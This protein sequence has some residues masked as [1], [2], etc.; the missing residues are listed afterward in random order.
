MLTWGEAVEVHA[1]RE[2]GWSIAAIARHLDRDPKTIRAYVN[3]EREPGR[4]A[5]DRRPTRW[6][7]SPT[8]WPPA[9]STTRTSGPAPCT[10]RCAGL[11]TA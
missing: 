8:T 9:S 2:R 5:A 1:L 6:R 3:G 7:R 10:T 4:R 11:A